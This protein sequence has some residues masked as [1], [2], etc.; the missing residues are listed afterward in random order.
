[1][2]KQIRGTAVKRMPRYNHQSAYKEY[3]EMV[4]SPLEFDVYDEVMRRV[5][6]KISKAIIVDK[7]E[8]KLPFSMGYIRIAKTSK[9][10]FY[11]FWDRL[12]PACRLRGRR[13]WI[14]TPARGTIDNYIGEKGLIGHFYKLKNNPYEEDYNVPR[15]VNHGKTGFF[16]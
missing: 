3:R 15:R 1:M 16:D 7:H 11:W 4:K 10:M 5:M 9:G 6:A 13:Y 2:P 14:F 12:N 8:W